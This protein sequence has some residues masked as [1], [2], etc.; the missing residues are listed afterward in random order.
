MLIEYCTSHLSAGSGITF[1]FSTLGHFHGLRI[2]EGGRTDVARGL[3][4]QGIAL[5]AGVGGALQLGQAAC[6][7][8]PARA[9]LRADAAQRAGEWPD[10]VM[11]QLLIGIS[12]G[13]ELL[14]ALASEVPA[15]AGLVLISASGLDPLEAGTLQA[16]R[17]GAAVV[18]RTAE[19]AVQARYGFRTWPVL[20][21]V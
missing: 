3:H 6:G 13:A 11:P 17:L 16:Q 19:K 9:A 4:G 14:P 2:V 5:S 21:F 15:L 12:E 7:L 8:H 1:N 20:V 18:A 10:A